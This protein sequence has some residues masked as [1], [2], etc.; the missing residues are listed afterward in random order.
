PQF[1]IARERF[2]PGYVPTPLWKLSPE[3][4]DE[5]VQRW[6]A[7]GLANY[8]AHSPPVYYLIAGAW[9]D[10]GKLLGLQNGYLL[11][12]TRFLN[13]PLY[14]ALVVVSYGF[15]RRYYPGRRYLVWSVPA[16]VAFFPQDIFY[17]VN[18]DVLSPL[19]FLAAFALLLEWDLRDPAPLWL[20]A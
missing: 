13:V 17:A 1:L 7:T 3:L 4:R 20:G 11:Y 10:L 8:E 5:Y 9:Y 16:L 6:L 14:A 12:W 2:P 15:C 18:S 19:F